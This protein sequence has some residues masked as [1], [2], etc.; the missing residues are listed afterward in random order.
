MPSWE[1]FE[2]QDQGYKDSVLPPDI[3]A[4]VAVEQASTFGWARYVGSAGESIGMKTFGASAPLRELQ[5]KFGFT[6][7]RIITAAKAQLAKGR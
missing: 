7:E 1:L 6:P 2:K 5:R 3:T 4:R